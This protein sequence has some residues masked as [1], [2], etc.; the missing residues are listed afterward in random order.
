MLAGACGGGGDEST[1]DL[2]ATGTTSST[3]TMTTTTTTT[4]DVG[5]TDPTGTAEQTTGTT[6]PP[7]PTTGGPGSATTTADTSVTDDTSDTGDTDTT[8]SARPVDLCAGLV[9]DLMP[10][11]MTPLA[12]PAVG[13]AVVDVEFGTTIRR[14]SSV[15]AV[16][17]TPVIKPAYSTIAAW[18]TDETRLILYDVSKGHLLYDGH[19]YAP[20]KSLPIAPPDLEQFYWHGSEPSIVMFVKGKTLV[21]FD[22]D[23]EAEEPVHTFEFCGGPASAGSDPMFSSWDSNRFGF[24]CDDQVFVYDVATDT[25]LGKQSLAENPPQV[26]PSGTLTFLSDSGKR[27]YIITTSRITSGDELK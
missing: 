23:S 21:R 4:S 16:G 10:R 3:T 15:E 19:T 6:E 27:T 2:S 14:I 8:G 7:E 25:V 13:E 5:T 1:G 24:K 9:Q 11:P 20:L 22:V 17:A 12:R 26:A 18:N